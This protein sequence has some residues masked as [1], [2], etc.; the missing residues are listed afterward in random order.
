MASR[1][2]FDAKHWRA[3]LDRWQQSGLTLHAFARHQNLNYLSLRYWRR[4]L[5]P[6]PVAEPTSV[7]AFVPL[8]LVAEPAV[9]IALPGGVV[10]KVPLAAS[11]EQIAVWLAAARTASC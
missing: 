6:P 4:K 11:A 9:E 7:A 1:Q 10:L 3:V 8:T 2:R 5:D